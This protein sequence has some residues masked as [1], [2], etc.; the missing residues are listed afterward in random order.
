MA[1]RPCDVSKSCNGTSNPMQAARPQRRGCRGQ[2]AEARGGHHLPSLLT[3]VRLSSSH[4]AGDGSAQHLT[5]CAAE[6]P[7]HHW[8]HWGGRQGHGTCFQ[9]WG[10][11]GEVTARL[12]RFCLISAMRLVPPPLHFHPS[13]SA[14]SAGKSKEVKTNIK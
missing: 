11:C 1:V 5:G 13:P 6:S 3:P 2:D 12:T 14:P 8:R 4:P 9:G 7:P 10:H